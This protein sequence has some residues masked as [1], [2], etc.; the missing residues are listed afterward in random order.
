M[1]IKTYIGDAG[2][3][4]RQVKKLYAGDANGIARELKALYVGDASGIARKI[5]QKAPLY[6]L[7]K[8]WWEADTSAITTNSSGII[9][10]SANNCTAIAYGL[11]KFVAMGS[12]LSRK[13]AYT[14][15]GTKWVQYM[16]ALPETVN[17]VT[18]NDLQFFDGT[19]LATAASSSTK[20]ILRSTTVSGWSYVKSNNTTYY[21]IKLAYGN[22]KVISRNSTY[23]FYSSDLGKTWSSGTLSGAG[24]TAVAYGNGKYVCL[25]T[26]SS[27]TKGSY[28]TDGINWSLFT[29]NTGAGGNYRK[30]IHA[31]GKFVAV[32]STT[33]SIYY[34]Y[35]A[36]TWYRASVPINKPWVDIAY[37]DGVFLAVPSSSSNTSIAYSNDGINWEEVTLPVA[38]SWRAIGFGVGTFAL[39]AYTT[40]G[41]P[42]ALF[43]RASGP[44]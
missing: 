24:G 41:K 37:G 9:D 36:L 31:A 35:D 4:A 43:S 8:D 5:F 19:F 27:S 34:S 12:T 11:G 6:R 32:N 44:A 16:S 40:K 39:L 33:E 2:G 20:G 22:G 42:K 10:S 26:S 28:S 3:I 21:P 15:D 7:G 1:A 23:G 25:P 14:T 17:S 30:I 18:I 38:A 13:L 29:L